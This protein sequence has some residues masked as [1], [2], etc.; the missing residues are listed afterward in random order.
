[1]L[2]TAGGSLELHAVKGGLLL[3]KAIMRASLEREESRGA[4]YREDFPERDDRNWL[5]NIVLTLDGE[6]GDFIVS[7]RPIDVH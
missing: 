2:E 6:T 5:K 4:F 7:H 3:S 1:L